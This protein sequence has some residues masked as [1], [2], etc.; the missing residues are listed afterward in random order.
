MTLTEQPNRK[1]QI[2][3]DFRRRGRLEGNP[4]RGQVGKEVIGVPA[5]IMNNHRI[6][7]LLCQGLSKLRDQGAV[8]MWH[9]NFLDCF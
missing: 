6:V 4:L 5:V 7:S 1:S 3:R 8:F 9:S 2:I